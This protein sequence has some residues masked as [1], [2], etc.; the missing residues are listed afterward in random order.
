M[1]DLRVLITE[2]RA[3]LGFVILLQLIQI[4]NW[5]M[6]FSRLGK[7]DGERKS[8]VVPMLYELAVRGAKRKLRNISRTPVVPDVDDEVFRKFC[9]VLRD[10]A[11]QR[12]VEAV[13]LSE[14][15]WIR[16]GAF[17]ELVG[18]SAEQFRACMSRLEA[19]GVLE[20]ADGRGRRTWRKPLHSITSKLKRMAYGT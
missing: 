15:F 2:L 7:L 5:W 1:D 16:E 18:G 17:R 6:V 3:Q 8:R 12:G 4:V 20:R 11:V 10:A 14:T 13:E 9:R 19:A